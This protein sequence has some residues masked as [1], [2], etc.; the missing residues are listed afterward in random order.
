MNRP[1][2]KKQALIYGVNPIREVLLTEGKQLD[3]IFL[4]HNRGGKA[5]DEIRLLAK[6][7]HTTVTVANRERLDQMAQT[8]KHQGIVAL[9]AATTYFDLD[10]LLTKAKAGPNPPFLFL[11][12]GVED[13]RNLGAILRTVD[14]VGG[15]GVI[16]PERRASGMTALVSKASAGASAHVPVARVVNLS[17][18]IDRIKKEGI[19]V[20]GLD[21]AGEISYL[22]YDY[23]YPLAIVVGG[24]GKGIGRKVLGRC[25]QTVALPM[26]GHVG[27]LN[28]GVSLGIISYEVLRQRRGGKT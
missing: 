8:P 28:V 14:A 6:Q 19:W 26:Y 18:A 24:E 22:E 15:D 4:L 27:S 12:D 21:L 11:I 16:I 17:N 1:E 2:N 13:P 20:V 25:D 9:M 10:E 5:I 3:K 7:Q 23:K